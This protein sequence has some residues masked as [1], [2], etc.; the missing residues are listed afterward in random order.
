MSNF[1]H[2][3]KSLVVFSEERQ[4]EIRWLFDALNNSLEFAERNADVQRSSSAASSLRHAKNL[5]SFLNRCFADLPDKQLVDHLDDFFAMLD[6]AID[7]SIQMP[8]V[9][10]L[11]EIRE[12]ITELQKG[13]ETLLMP[14]TTV[15]AE[16]NQGHLM[17]IA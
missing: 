15:P 17:S 4:Q 3:V 1:T 16:E 14:S 10:D 8:L 9:E 6:R 7:Q 5:L 12:L 2:Y 13:W 11:E